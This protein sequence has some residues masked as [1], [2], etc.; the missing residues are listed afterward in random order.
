MTLER[1]KPM[2]TDPL[3]FKELSGEH[4]TTGAP[5]DPLGGLRVAMYSHDTCGLG[6][7][8][9]NLLMAD[10][11]SGPALGA[12]V[13]AIAGAAE[14]KLF[15]MPAGVDCITLPAL[16]KGSDGGYRSRSLDLDLGDLIQL[17][18]ATIRAALAAFRPDIF[19]VDKV[20]RGAEG[21]LDSVLENLAANGKTRIVLGL[22]D[23]LDHRDS[24]QKEW[25]ERGYQAA[26]ARYYDAV[27]VYGDRR[28]QDMAAEYGFSDTVADRLTYTGYLD[29]RA[30]ESDRGT[31]AQPASAGE[32]IA[33]CMLGGG[34][35]GEALAES[36]AT[37]SLPDG[38][39]GIVLTGPFMP[40]SAKRMLRD[41]AS[42]QP[43]IEVEEF[44]SA[45][46]Q[47]IARA[48]RVVAMGGFNTVYEVL[49]HEK[50][51]LIVPRVSP[52]REQLVR[53]ERLSE[54]GLVDICH[55]DLASPAAIGSWLAR[56]VSPPASA[57]ERLDFGGLSRLPDLVKS[58]I[59][60]ASASRSPR[61]FDPSRH[62]G[63]ILRGSSPA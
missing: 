25:A 41:I 56:D 46:D 62:Q 40:E 48:E 37:A 2:R 57:R 6:H 5:T 31:T 42:N 55:P 43:A 19:I 32:R 38:M 29:R 28:V 15:P 63:P 4:G 52:R 24:V 22:R 51:M 18:A 60:P 35:D 54:M 33:L 50:P 8:R 10:V 3:S 34:Q 20:P 9:R 59:D 53:A 36:F 61:T 21:E 26:I 47:L 11:L 49:S 17:R 14:A 58:V 12:N 13:L 27:W 23:V 45:P 44:R 16:T 30:L 39:K 7:L 1:L